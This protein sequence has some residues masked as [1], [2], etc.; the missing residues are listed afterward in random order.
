MKKLIVYKPVAIYPA[1]IYREIEKRHSKIQSRKQKTKATFLRKIFIILFFFV[2]LPLENGCKTYTKKMIQH[3]YTGQQAQN[4]KVI[5]AEMIK[6]GITN[7]Y[8]QVGILSVIGKESGFIPQREKSYSGTSNERLRKLFG[9]RLSKYTDEQ[10]TYI[11]RDD[12]AFFDAIYGIGT[13]DYFKWQTGNT[14]KGDGWKYRGGGL[15]QITFKNLFKK[16][17]PI[18]GVDLVKYPEKINEIEIAAKLAVYFMLEP[19]KKRG[20]NIDQIGPDAVHLFVKAN[21]GKTGDMQDTATYKAAKQI[22]KNFEII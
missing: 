5:I 12:I 22:E 18:A 17:S 15:N 1:G 14:E 13:K 21:A 11:K 20:V 7:E 2:N 6:Q 4:I 10:L 8:A 19:I 9:R 3:N 16:Y